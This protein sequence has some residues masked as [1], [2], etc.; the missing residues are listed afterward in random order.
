M[1]VLLDSLFD[2]D[3][4]LRSNHA[5]VEYLNLIAQNEGLDIEARTGNPTGGGIH[6]KLGLLRVG[7]ETW[8]V[9]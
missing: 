2:D 6:M 7:G 8:T 9:K 5:T 4:A 3:D 1:H